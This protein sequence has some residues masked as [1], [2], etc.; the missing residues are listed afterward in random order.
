MSGI[1]IRRPQLAATLWHPLSGRALDVSSNAPGIQVYSGNFLDGSLVGKHNVLYP[2]KMA[3]LPWKPRC[4]PCHVHPHAWLIRPPLAM[5]GIWNTVLLVGRT[6]HVQQ[7]V[8]CLRY[9]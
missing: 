3:G 8:L 6:G 4:A 5:M 9:V 1:V 7:A 2:P